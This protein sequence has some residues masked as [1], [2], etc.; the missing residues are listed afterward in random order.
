MSKHKKSNIG[1]KRTNMCACNEVVTTYVG[2]CKIYIKQLLSADNAC[3]YETHDQ[4]I[5]PAMCRQ[6]DEIYLFYLAPL[7]N[8]VFLSVIISGLFYAFN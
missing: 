5:K 4:I 1:R 6:S 8:F 3:K 2:V 7:P